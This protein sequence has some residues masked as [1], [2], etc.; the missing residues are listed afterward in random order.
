MVRVVWS[1]CG[2]KF[3]TVKAEEFNGLGYSTDEISPYCSVYLQQ[4]R[5]VDGSQEGVGRSAPYMPR[6]DQTTGGSWELV[7]SNW[8]AHR[9]SIKGTKLLFIVIKAIIIINI[10]EAAAN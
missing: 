8:M 6:T 10:G 7:S 5:I 3:N 4:T 2:H 1:G 9:P